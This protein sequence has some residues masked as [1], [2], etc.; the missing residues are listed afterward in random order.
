MAWVQNP[1]GCAKPSEKESPQKVATGQCANTFQGPPESVAGVTL[2]RAGWGLSCRQGAGSASS[3]QGRGLTIP[4]C[5]EASRW[6]GSRTWLARAVRV[7]LTGSHQGTKTWGEGGSGHHVAL[8]LPPAN[9]SP[10]QEVKG[11]VVFSSNPQEPTVDATRPGPLEGKASLPPASSRPEGGGPR[12]IPGG[13]RKTTPNRHTL[14]RLSASRSLLGPLTQP[15]ATLLGPSESAPFLC[16][17]WP[18]ILLS[19]SEPQFPYL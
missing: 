8:R 17:S 18:R 7:Q 14:S 11:A 4:H 12:S 6:A 15:V 5:P 2:P 9:G 19:S 13:S 3:G 1:P 10:G 16:C